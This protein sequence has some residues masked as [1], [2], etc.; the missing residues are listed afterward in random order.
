MYFKIMM[1]IISNTVKIAL[2]CLS[3]YLLE[4]QHAK[5]LFLK[6]N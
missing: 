3:T 2:A 1:F 4:S 5:D 6:I